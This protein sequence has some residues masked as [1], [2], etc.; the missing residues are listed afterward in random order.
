MLLTDFFNAMQSIFLLRLKFEP[1]VAAK[2]MSDNS[3]RLERMFHEGFAPVEAVSAL[4][5]YEL[6]ENF[7]ATTG[8][9]IETQLRIN[10]ET[11]EPYVQRVR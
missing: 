8:E 9:P 4:I 1:G 3:G 2:L 6:S 7:D 11:G 10:P 5:G